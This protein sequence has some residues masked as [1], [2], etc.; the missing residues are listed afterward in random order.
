M[1]YSEQWDY[2]EYDSGFPAHQQFT[3]LSHVPDQLPH[4]EARSIPDSPI[5]PAPANDIDP[6]GTYISEVYTA[7]GFML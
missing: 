7:D 5:E 1:H 2:P 6:D 3:R 4:H